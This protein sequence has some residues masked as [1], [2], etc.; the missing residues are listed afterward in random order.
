MKTIDT[1]LKDLLELQKDLE[2]RIQ[3][4]KQSESFVTVEKMALELMK[5]KNAIV[6]LQPI[7]KD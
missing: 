2:S 1:I 6:A 3:Q 4:A 5:V 7:V